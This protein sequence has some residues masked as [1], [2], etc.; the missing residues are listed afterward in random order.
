M[1]EPCY[2][3]YKACPTCVDKAVADAAK[4]AL[5]AEQ[6][7]DARARLV[8]MNELARKLADTRDE[9]RAEFGGSYDEM[10]DIAESV[11]EGSETIIRAL[12]D[13]E[14]GIDKCSEL[15]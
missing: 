15:I 3:G 10:R 6:I 12:R 1:C 9:L 14:D 11:G 13:L 4:A 7:G 5:T 8:K 2:G